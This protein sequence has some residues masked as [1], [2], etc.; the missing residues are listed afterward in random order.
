MDEAR[1]VLERLERIDALREG[2][3]EPHRLLEELRA[4]LVE[5]EAWLAVE[6][7]DGRACGDGS[8]EAAGGTLLAGRAF[9]ELGQALE[10]ARAARLA[11]TALSSEDA[12]HR[13]SWTRREVVAETPRV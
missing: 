7:S 2:E 9:A 6:R 13:A 4:L 8:E 10:R 11:P 3:A 1:R 5:G 12:A